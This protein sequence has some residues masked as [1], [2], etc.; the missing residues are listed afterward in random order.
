MILRALMPGLGAGG[1]GIHH[2]CRRR[3]GL[4]GHQCPADKRPPPA[5]ACRFTRR[6]AAVVPGGTMGGGDQGRRTVPTRL[7]I[8]HPGIA[9][10]YARCAPHGLSPGRTSALRH[11][12]RLR[13]GRSPIKSLAVAP[14][15]VLPSRPGGQQTGAD[16]DEAHD[17]YKSAIRVPKNPGPMGKRRARLEWFGRVRGADGKQRWIKASDLRAASGSQ[18]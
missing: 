10:S 13:K 18:P 9:N 12:L 1:R 17:S 3:P 6:G 4:S 11:I 2:G 8:T 14:T 7:L 5:P 16:D 15:C